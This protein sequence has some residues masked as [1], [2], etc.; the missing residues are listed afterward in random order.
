[1]AAAVITDSD[2]G[3]QPPARIEKNIYFPRIYLFLWQQK[4][5]VQAKKK[6]L[7]LFISAQFSKIF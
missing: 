5:T 2:R 1:M 4:L 3:N 6:D 7:V